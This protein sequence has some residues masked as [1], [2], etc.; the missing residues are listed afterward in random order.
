MQLDWNSCYGNIKTIIQLKKTLN[1]GEIPHDFQ[2]VANKLI[3]LEGT[4]TDGFRNNVT[5][6]LDQQ[7]WQFANCLGG[8][9]RVAIRRHI[10]EYAYDVHCFPIIN[11][12]PHA[13]VKPY[14]PESCFKEYNPA[15]VG[16]LIRLPHLSDFISMMIRCGDEADIELLKYAHMLVEQLNQLLVRSLDVTENT[17]QSI[18]EAFLY[19][20]K[21]IK[22]IKIN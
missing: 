17:G 16:P 19:I 3:E 9:P 12:T 7:N 11:N 21:Q 18:K 15:S 8:R 10:D 14:H 1:L 5:H 6:L 22:D 13:V 2:I 4:F 20:E